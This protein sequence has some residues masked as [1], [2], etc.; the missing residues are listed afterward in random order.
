MNNKN[1][2]LYPQGFHIGH[3]YLLIKHIGDGNFEFP[4]NPE[5]YWPNEYGEELSGTSRQLRYKIWAL[6]EMGI[7]EDQRIT[8]NHLSYQTLTAKGRRIYELLNTIELPANFLDRQAND[9][10]IMEYGD[11]NFIH[12]TQSL[13]NICPELFELLK[14]I[15]LEMKSSQDLIKYFVEKNI[16]H[17]EKDEL[18]ENYFDKQYVKETYRQS[19][20]RPPRRSI[21]TA[22]R[23]ISVIVGLLESVNIIKGWGL[24]DTPISI[25]DIPSNIF[26]EKESEIES[27]LQQTI[28]PLTIE[29]IN[30]RLREL[31]IQLQGIEPVVDNKDTINTTIP[32]YPRNRNLELL[33]KKRENY[34]CQYC[35]VEG[36]QKENE[37]NNDIRY[38]E[39]HH[40]I[41][42]RLG[43]EYG[44]NPDV[45]S[46]I[47]VLCS[48]CHVKFEYGTQ[49]LKETMYQN[50]LEREIINQE[51]IAELRRF[52]I[53]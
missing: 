44:S 7:L 4:F 25:C 12:F 1:S 16:K 30:D 51:K 26:E 15:F 29:E 47:I 49:E 5:T 10:W 32:K 13:E 42:M 24:R 36:F 34:H 46:N 28:T 41:P 11:R 21:E 20:L 19:G 3:L 53:I 2:F 38:I 31:Q 23:R 40:M 39:C 48:W 27:Q 45:P 33:M 35:N 14:T 37:R 22:R 43:Q 52:N 50:L 8:N 17:I 9:S 18:Y 6:M